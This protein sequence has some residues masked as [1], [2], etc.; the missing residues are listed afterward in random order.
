MS[1]AN[2][3][4]RR[5]AIREVWLS[6]AGPAIPQWAVICAG[7]PPV[8]LTGAYLISDALQPTS[9]SPIRETISAMAGY[10]GTDRWVMTGG[11]L[12]VGMCYLL[13]AAGLSSIRASARVLLVVA[14]LAGI[15]IAASP[16]PSSGPTPQHLA[17]TTLGAITI[18][19]WPAFTARGVSPRPLILTRY[20]SAAVTAVFAALLGW[21]VIQ[22][23]DGSVLGLAERLTSTV[24]TSWPFIVAAALR[25]ARTSST[26]ADTVPGLHGLALDIPSLSVL[27]RMRIWFWI[28][29]PRLRD[30]VGES[31]RNMD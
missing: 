2:R 26:T 29:A 3:K 4:A 9:Y 5:L 28:L 15:G 16:E 21:L 22:T 19:S 27:Y 17:W 12:L 24:Q 7:L 1:T 13:T 31:T 8:L 25:R 11:I 6:R 23:R 14:G 10:A 18:A 20:G 30:R